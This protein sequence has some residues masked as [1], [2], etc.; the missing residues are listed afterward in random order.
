M[1]HTRRTLMLAGAA[2][3]ASRLFGRTQGMLIHLSCGAIGVKAYTP[4]AVEMAAKYGF[5]AIDADGKYLAGLSQ[6]EMAELLDRMH[7]QKGHLGDGGVAGGVP[8]GRCGVR[9]IDEELSG[10]RRRAEARGCDAMHHVDL[11]QQR[12]SDVPGEFQAA[13]AAI[14]RSGRACCRIRA[15]GWAGVCRVRRR[16][17]ARSDIRSSTRWRR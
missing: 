7:V 5:D 6:G 12:Q 13:R 14:A 16:C 4:E 2:G 10:F 3:L 1:M 15:S 11:A 17:G 8:Q 9:G